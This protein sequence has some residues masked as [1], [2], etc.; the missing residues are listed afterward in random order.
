VIS[1]QNE[2]IRAAAGRA[3]QELI[4]SNGTN[5][6]TWAQVTEGFT[7][8]GRKIY[9]ATKA[10]GIF[11][12]AELTDNAA[13]SIKQV[14]PSRS[15]RSAP[16]DDRELREGLV[17]YRLQRDGRDTRFNTLLENA[18]LQ[19][20]PLLF[21][22]GLADSLYE[23]LYPVFVE[24]ISFENDAAMIGFDVPDTILAESSG[25]QRV[26]ELEAR[27]GLGLRRTRL[28]QSAFRK[29][30][31]LAYGLRCAL[32]NLPLVELLQAAHIVRDS[33][34]GIPSVQNGIAMST[35]HHSAYEENLI[36]IDPD[37][38]IHLS[39]KAASITDGPMYDHGLLRLNGSTIRFPKFEGHRPN[40]DFLA[41]KF[42]EFKKSA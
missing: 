28:H 19:R 2:E 21:F 13:L 5:V 29:R 6:L 8:A 22:K 35:F 23:V 11:K 27:Y 31:L 10:A 32:T 37:G 18:Y 34:G 26:G 16:Y 17:S 4:R 33:A 15:G 24:E 1:S 38:K 7:F 20:E 39:D 14:L 9:W 12:P 41:V 25:S 42:E 3:I 36:G 40:R 30:V